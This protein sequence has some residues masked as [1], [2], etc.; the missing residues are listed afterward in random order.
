M[1]DGAWTP[2]TSEN[3]SLDT[4]YLGKNLYYQRGSR[5]QLFN[6]K[7]RTVQYHVLFKPVGTIF[8][9]T[10]ESNIKVFPDPKCSRIRVVKL[11]LVRLGYITLRHVERKKHEV[12]DV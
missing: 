1:L 9:G 12:V 2:R 7:V 3:S 8:K 5:Y 6:A 4:F 11:E 10:F